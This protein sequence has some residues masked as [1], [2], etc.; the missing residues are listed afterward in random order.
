RR[1]AASAS[2]SPATVRRAAPSRTSSTDPRPPARSDSASTRIDLP[3]PV[4]PVMTVSPASSSISRSS[5]MARF[6]TVSRRSMTGLSVGFARCGS[7]A[8][9]APASGSAGCGLGRSPAPFSRYASRGARL[10]PRSARE[11]S[12]AA[13]WG[14]CAAEYDGG[15]DIY[16]RGDEDTGTPL[17]ARQAGLLLAD[18][19]GGDAGGDDARGHRP[20][21]DPHGADHRIGLDRDTRE[22]DG[23]AGGSGAIDD[24]GS[25]ER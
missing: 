23:G 7:C 18:R 9:G 17:G 10:L 25:G 13:N 20:G 11:T 24:D 19:P 22:D 15:L 12:R 2:N 1:T 3:A 6:L 16:E 14:E 4:S 5:T 21:G 8:S